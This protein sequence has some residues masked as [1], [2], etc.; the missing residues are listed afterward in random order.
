LNILEKIIYKNN[1]RFFSTFLISGFTFVVV[2]V[3]VVVAGGACGA[4]H[5]RT[6]AVG[7][8][9]GGGLRA[10]VGFLSSLPKTNMHTAVRWLD[11]PPTAPP[12]PDATE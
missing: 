12:P 2:V 6:P 7:R 4:G 3:V 9:S 10:E 11:R 1:S 8:V 5:S